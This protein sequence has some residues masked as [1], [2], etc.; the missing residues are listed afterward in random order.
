MKVLFLFLFVLFVLVTLAKGDEADTASLFSFR[1]FMEGQWQITRSSVDISTG[2]STIDESKG[3]YS[4]EPESE[5]FFGLKGS[6]FLNSTDGK[7]TN[8]NRVMIE[9]GK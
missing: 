6:Y 5:D 8:R 1:A 9:F 4:L 3:Y 2:Q 7:V